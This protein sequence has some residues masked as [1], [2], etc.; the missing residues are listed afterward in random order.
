MDRNT[1]I[2]PGMLQ[3]RIDL[4]ELTGLILTCLGLANDE[5]RTQPSRIIGEKVKASY[6]MAYSF[7]TS[8]ITG[9]RPLKVTGDFSILFRV[10]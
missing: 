6:A 3:R 7:S 9:L 1:F 4:S 10:Q 2:L 8:T 5:R